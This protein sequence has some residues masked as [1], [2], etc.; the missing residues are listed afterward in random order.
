MAQ[1]QQSASYIKLA[2]HLIIS[3][4]CLMFPAVIFHVDQYG[5]MYTVTDHK[6][7]IAVLFIRKRRTTVHFVSESKLL[8]PAIQNPLDSVRA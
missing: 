4:T 5:S 2:N 6:I 7:I 1:I 3:A 8:E